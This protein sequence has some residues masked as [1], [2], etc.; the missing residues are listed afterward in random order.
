[1]DTLRRH[2]LLSLLALPAGCALQP[3][4]PLITEPVPPPT[5]PLEVRP[6]APGQTWT[7]QKYNA[8]NSQPLQLDR[9][10]VV[11]ISPQVVVR[12]TSTPEQGEREEHHQP[13][14][15][16]VRDTTW[17]IVQNYET[18]QPLWPN[19]LAVGASETRDTHYRVS[20]FSFRYWLQTR[21]TVHGWE[22]VQ[23]AAGRFEALRIEHYITLKHHDISRLRT[24]RHDTQWL[25]PQIG[26]W[27]AR[28]ISGEYQNAGD[29][30][31]RGREDHVRWELTEWH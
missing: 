5:S 12:R 2:T 20:D 24:V 23:V 9:D 7:Y 16:V 27:V 31:D 14:G 19:T 11:A 30:G 10:E 3:L 21:T 22:R 18:P 8:Y 13:W 25:V 17:D 1:M 15:Q 6:A 28:E 29:Q 26:R 4:R